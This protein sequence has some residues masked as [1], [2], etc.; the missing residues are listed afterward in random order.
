MA[1]AASIAVRFALYVDLMLLFGIPAFALSV[2]GRQGGDRSLALRP[3]V[4]ACAMVGLVLSAAGIALLAASMSG[5]AVSAVE[6]SSVR[7][8]VAETASGT[9][10]LVR[11]AALVTALVIVLAARDGRGTRVALTLIGGVAL[12]T[13]AWLGHGVMN[14]GRTGIAHLV[15]DIGHLVAAGIWV[16]ALACLTMMIL[17]PVDD[18]DARR[19]D[20]LH[21]AL[22]GFGLVGA[23]AVGIIVV[24]GLVNSWLLVGYENVG[25]LGKTLYGQLL[26]AK[27]A[28]FGGMLGLAALN[29][30]RL[31]PALGRAAAQGDTVAAV[32]ALRLSLVFEAASAAAI[33]AL[34]AWLGTLAPPMSTM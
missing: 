32:R 1:D 7:L 27:L 9:A 30:F 2:T 20:D 19:R 21:R 22:A 29:R 34:V 8:L 17:R 23:V 4:T 33:L 10:W 31:A 15:A 3:I 13:L 24:T 25:S 28:L 5:V 16:G 14:D 6:L 18:M 26:L 12:A 11:V